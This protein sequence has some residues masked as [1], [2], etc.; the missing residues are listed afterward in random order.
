MYGKLKILYPKKYEITDEDFRDKRYR[1]Y[2]SLDLF[3]L[4][5]YGKKLNRLKTK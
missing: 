2:C 4:A 1:Y 3:S 5:G